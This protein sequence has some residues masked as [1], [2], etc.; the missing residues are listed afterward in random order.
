MNF[1]KYYIN[2]NKYSFCILYQTKIYRFHFEG[3]WN[4][5]MY[6]LTLFTTKRY[7][8]EKEGEYYSIYYKFYFN[9]KLIEKW[10]DKENAIK[11]VIELNKNLI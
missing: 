2:G 10:K 1:K 6:E 5:L 9:K 4:N 7:V 11:R 3:N 8:I